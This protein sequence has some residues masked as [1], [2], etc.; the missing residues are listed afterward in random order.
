MAAAQSLLIFPVLLCGSCSLMCWLRPERGRAWHNCSQMARIK[1]R[2][3]SWSL[4]NE[5]VSKDMEIPSV[6]ARLG[7]PYHQTNMDYRRQPRR[8]LIQPCSQWA[9]EGVLAVTLCSH[10]S[11]R[12]SDADFFQ[13][14]LT[15]VWCFLISVNCKNLHQLPSGG[16]GSG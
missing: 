2:T 5:H 4:L 12:V 10:C 1:S 7:A 8:R 3:S 13:S 14:H 11:W 9:G 16:R 15:P 6:T